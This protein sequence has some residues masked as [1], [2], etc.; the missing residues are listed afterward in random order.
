MRQFDCR[1]ARRA[2]ARYTCVRTRATCVYV[3]ALR[4][5]GCVAI[6]NEIVRSYAGV[7]RVVLSG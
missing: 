4:V 2:R 5:I 1:L 3:H 6:V 7:A